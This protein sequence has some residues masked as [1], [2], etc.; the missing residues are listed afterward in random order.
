VDRLV[1]LQVDG[2]GQ[3]AGWVE[4]YSNAERIEPAASLF[5]RDAGD[6]L[7]EHA[8]APKVTLSGSLRH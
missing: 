5:D 7:G 8:H 4:Q 2:V 6:E 1:D 3:A